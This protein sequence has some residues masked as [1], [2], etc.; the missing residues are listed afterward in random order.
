[1]QSATLLVTSMVMALFYV[2]TDAAPPSSSLLGNLLDNF[3]STDPRVPMVSVVNLGDPNDVHSVPD[4]NSDIW[5]NKR[6]C[7]DSRASEK[8]Q[9]V[10][11]QHSQFVND[12]VLNMCRF[13][14]AY[15]ISAGWDKDAPIS[16]CTNIDADTQV[17]EGSPRSLRSIA[18]M[19]TYR[20]ASNIREDLLPGFGPVDCFAI[21]WPPLACSA[22]GEFIMLYDSSPPRFFEAKGD[23]NRGDCTENGYR[24]ILKPDGTPGTEI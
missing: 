6:T 1:M 7:Y 16:I 11:G 10:G 22:G 20:G 2:L 5:K 24:L 21:L 4:L 13:I 18:I 15:T 9:D 23:P 8:W 14:T 17:S 3:N 19:V 12:T